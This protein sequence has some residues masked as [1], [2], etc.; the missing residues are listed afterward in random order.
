VAPKFETL[1]FSRRSTESNRVYA[2][3]AICRQRHCFQGNGGASEEYV[4]RGSVRPD[5]RNECNNAIEE[6]T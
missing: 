4:F 2:V 1:D 5:V 6:G 3:R